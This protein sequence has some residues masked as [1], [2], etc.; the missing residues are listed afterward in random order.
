MQYFKLTILLLFIILKAIYGNEVI[1]TLSMMTDDTREELSSYVKKAKGSLTLDEFSIK[2]GISKYH[3]SRII[4]GKIKNIP[5]ESTIISI[6]NASESKA[7]R[8]FL[9]WCFLSSETLA[10][11]E[12]IDPELQPIN[13]KYELIPPSSDDFVS[14]ETKRKRGKTY[15]NKQLIQSST[16][17]ILDA[18]LDLPFEWTRKLVTCPVKH[19]LNNYIC[20]EFP[21]NAPFI[22]WH[23]FFLED[24][25]Y[26]YQTYLLSTLGI[27][28]NQESAID[29]KYTI[30]LDSQRRYE[31]ARRYRND[32]ADAHG[33]LFQLCIAQ[34]PDLLGSIAV[35]ISGVSEIFLQ[36]QMA[37][38][39]QR[40]AD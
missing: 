19:F 37:P 38:V 11:E 16:S 7:V 35:Q 23:F 18:L 12:R 40:V 17:I 3:L 22:K 2:S 36:L 29:E 34:I 5:R 20:I 27:L 28:L 9:K 21:D 4:N 14:N 15:Y 10:R 30:I 33:I 1:K 25:P 26:D 8:R 31:Q 13:G 39:V 24:H 32:V 6:A